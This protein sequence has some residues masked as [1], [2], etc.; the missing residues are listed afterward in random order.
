MKNTIK[1]KFPKGIK[2]AGANSKTLVSALTGTS[3]KKDL[4]IQLKKIEAVNDLPV[5]ER[6]DI[7]SD[8]S[9]YNSGTSLYKHI[10][11]YF[12]DFIVSTLPVYQ[13][14]RTNGQI[15]QN[16]LLEITH[17]QIEAGI[18]FLTI[19]PTPNRLLIKLAQRRRVPW[20]SRGGAIVMKDL[21]S[22]NPADDNV[23]IKILD[24][25]ISLAKKNDVVI[26]IGASYRSAN[27]FDSLDECQIEEFRSQ[28]SIGEY[29]ENNG[30]KVIVEGPGHS[31]PQKLKLIA[32]YY[33]EMSFPVM[34]LGPIPTDTAIGQDHISS[35]IGAVIL[36]LYNSVDIITAVTRE[37]HTGGIPSIKSTIEA[38]QAAKI[39]A[40]I[41]DIAKLEDLSE[42]NKIVSFREQ[43][44][45]CIYGKT[46]AG[47]S[48]C[49]DVCPLQFVTSM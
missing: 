17:E 16:E 44:Q 40:H 6:P 11:N 42:D 32:D 22:S 21:L 27:V 43:H 8:L 48:R 31:T 23:Y 36:G 15:S 29:I 39:A 26:S 5:N 47:C 14:K 7:I 18:G 38:L 12:P 3:S 9:I 37:E 24:D 1:L 4:A 41:I 30:V 28:K 46:N 34:P 13:C 25:L 20:T 49:M 33:N 45:T 19:H 35:A 2:Y 10:L